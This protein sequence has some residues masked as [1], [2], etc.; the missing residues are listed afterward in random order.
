MG[1]HFF[2]DDAYTKWQQE[3]R[4]AI[5]DGYG[6]PEPINGPF[7]VSMTFCLKSKG[8]SDVDN[9]FA[10]VLD[11]LQP[12][13][14]RGRQGDV[15]LYPGVL[16]TDDRWLRAFSCS[17]LPAEEVGWEGIE[18]EVRP[19]EEIVWKPKKRSKRKAA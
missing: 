6:I 8:N 2:H 16:W 17:Y 12:P 7:E 3:M 10:G 19:V 15:S 11:S 9:L 18:L 14:A 13:G 5:V 4:A 1:R